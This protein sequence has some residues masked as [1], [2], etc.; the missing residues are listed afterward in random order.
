M[1]GKKRSAPRKRERSDNLSVSV[2]IYND[3]LPYALARKMLEKVKIL[4][5]LLLIALL[6]AFLYGALY[7]NQEISPWN[8]QTIDYVGEQSSPPSII[9]DSED[10]P[11]ICYIDRLGVDNQTLKYA[12]LT[13]SG[14]V[15]QKVDN[16][17]IMSPSIAL[18][19]GRNPH[20]CYIDYNVHSLKYATLTVNGWNITVLEQLKGGGMPSLAIDSN[21][22]PSIVY[23]S[24][25]S[26][27]YARW[28]GVNWSISTIDLMDIGRTSSL[29]LDSQNNPH[30]CYS[31]GGWLN[32]TIK[33]ASFQQN[34]WVTEN[35]DYDVFDLPPPSLALDSDNNPCISYYQRAATYGYLKYAKWAW[36][37]WSIQS[38]ELASP[39][40]SL[41]LDSEGN[42]H[43]SYCTAYGVYTR[44]AVGIDSQ[45]NIQTVDESKSLRSPSLAL[46]SKDNPHMACSRNI[47]HG[48]ATTTYGVAYVTQNCITGIKSLIYTIIGLDIFGLLIMII[49]LAKALR[50][51]K[52]AVKFEPFS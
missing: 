23:A 39:G 50:K 17:M 14:W 28:S 34:R 20:I 31:T 18:D 4:I 25:Y 48:H 27:K 24:D 16:G 44:Y 5:F 12:T 52:K 37:N 40:S 35:V 19:E 2:K 6:L 3:G 42:A 49:L 21:G 13:N 51:I 47:Y 15:V 29:I 1:F 10:N 33:Y 9:L 22:N 41:S 26:L 11:H 36:A 46:D 45:W 30:V 38:V 7:Y 32:W 43:V 8:I